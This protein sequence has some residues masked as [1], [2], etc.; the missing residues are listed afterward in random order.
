MLNFIDLEK[1]NEIVIL[2][3]PKK[4]VGKIREE[5]KCLFIPFS[6]SDRSS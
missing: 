6:Q 3:Q 4:G 5:Q 1:Y 2:L